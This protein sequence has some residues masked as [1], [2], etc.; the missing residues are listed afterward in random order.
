MLAE[1][2]NTRLSKK[3]LL[4]AGK[5]AADKAF[6]YFD[7]DTIV[8]SDPSGNISIQIAKDFGI[9]IAGP[10][11]LMQNPEEIRVAGMW[12]I[13]PLVIAALPST[14]YTPV[15]W[16]RRSTPKSSA[17]L[18]KGIDEVLALI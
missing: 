13:N 14:L 3:I 10:L 9:G 18:V 12:K 1:H 15:P 2:Y 16:L 4:H 6:A 5:D 11:S 7:D 17:E 8:I